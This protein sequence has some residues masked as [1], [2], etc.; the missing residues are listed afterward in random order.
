MPLKLQNVDKLLDKS[1][2]ICSIDNIGQNGHY[3]QLIHIAQLH[4]HVFV[5]ISIVID[6]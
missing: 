2:H 4:I 3:G 5:D 1:A 6:L